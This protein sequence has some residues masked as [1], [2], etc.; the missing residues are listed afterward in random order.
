VIKGFIQPAH[1]LTWASYNVQTKLYIQ[2]LLSFFMSNACLSDVGILGIGT[3]CKCLKLTATLG[4]K[5]LCMLT[6]SKVENFNFSEYILQ[7]LQTRF[8]KSHTQDVNNSS[9]DAIKNLK[10]TVL[11]LNLIRQPTILS[12]WYTKIFQQ[13]GLSKLVDTEIWQYE[14][15]CSPDHSLW[16]ANLNYA[17]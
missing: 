3:T 2:Q 16:E 10:F 12:A 8:N 7:Y 1:G 15:Y 11:W 5:V 13:L 17:I 14:T 6:V 9:N 4:Q